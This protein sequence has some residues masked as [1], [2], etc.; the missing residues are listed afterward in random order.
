MRIVRFHLEPWQK[1]GTPSPSPSLLLSPRISRR[2]RLPLSSDI[3]NI[4]ILTDREREKRL[5]RKLRY[6]YP[7]MAKKLSTLCLDLLA[8]NVLLR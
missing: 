1:G 8:K 7:Q 3:S 6:R 4:D 2:Q 5:K